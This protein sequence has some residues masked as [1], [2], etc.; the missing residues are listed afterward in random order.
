MT[1]N[2]NHDLTI[3]RQILP[4]PLR[5]LGVLGP[6]KRTQKT[7]EDLRNEGIGPSE[8]QISH[9]YSRLEWI[10]AQKR[11]KR[12]RWQ[13]LEKFRLYLQVVQEVLLEIAKVR[14][15]KVLNRFIDNALLLRL[16]LDLQQ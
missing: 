7:F 11:Q 6:K 8:D 10:S 14:S 13:S 3:L 9:I 16:I 2:Y 1:H 15:T 5:Y 4:R 12:L